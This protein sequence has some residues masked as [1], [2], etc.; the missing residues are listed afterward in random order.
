MATEA[1]GTGNHNKRKKRAHFF[2]TATPYILIAPAII[3]YVFFWLRP[4]VTLVVSSFTSA[5]TA[6]FTLENFGLVFQDPSFWPAVL[7]TTIIVIFSVTLEFILAILLALL[8]NQKFPGSSAFLFIA[9]IPMALPAMAVAAMWQTGLTAHG[10][11]NSLLYYMGFLAEGDKIYF[12]TGSDM[13]NLFII[14]LVDAWTVIPSVMI[15]LLAG[16]QN[17]PEEMKE[18]GY[19]FGGSWGTVL[20]KITFPM[21]KSTIQTAVILRLIAAIQIWLIIVMLFGFNRLPVLVERVVYYTDEVSGLNNAFQLAA[22]YTIIVSLV[23]S[24][25]AIFFLQVSGAFKKSAEDK[26]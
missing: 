5:E 19:I 16:L 13:K 3:Y 10:W 15:I 12:L 6:G 18:A 25:A 2:R 21:L 20:R 17:L 1:I 22:A 4:V 26:R 8:I 9:L 23:V 7:N 24:I 11:I 14:I